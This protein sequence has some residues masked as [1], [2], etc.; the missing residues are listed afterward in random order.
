MKKIGIFLNRDLKKNAG[1]PSG[2]LYNLKQGLENCSANI[3]F[4]T[5]NF[6]E[7]ERQGQGKK[8]DKIK[9]ND[10]FGDL[11]LALSFALK[12]I[13]IKGKINSKIYNM[14]VIHVHSSE[15]LF[16][17]RAILKYKGK[18]VFTPHRPET[19]ASE[20]INTQKLLHN[21]T[22][23]YP[24]LK[25]ICKFLEV[26]SYKYADAFIFPSPHARD[27]YKKFP[28]FVKYANKTP[29]KYVYTG[30]RD[31]NITASLEDYRYINKNEKTIFAFVGRHNYI[32]GYDLL[33]DVFTHIVKYNV[34]VICAGVISNIEHPKSNK[35]VELGYINNSNSLMK[36]ADCIIIPNRNTYFDLIIVEALAVGAIIIT[37]DTGGNIDIAK[38]TN[39]MILFESG[40]MESLNNAIEKFLHMSKDQKRMMRENNRRF[41]DENCSIDRFSRS[42]YR[43]ITDL[44]KNIEERR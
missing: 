31:V 7:T 28:G 12:G 32:K 11:R 36:R 6:N 29:T 20:V 26:Y 37:S 13:K 18:I 15:D 4:F 5:I 3:Y 30:T 33:V 25:K 23:N 43:A 9:Y 42:Y 14:D 22:Y 41:Y 24:F 35:W 19:L 38:G 17:L 8:K 27:I 16:A 1:G 44:S 2:Y 40:N 21:T 34:E 39:G 10:I